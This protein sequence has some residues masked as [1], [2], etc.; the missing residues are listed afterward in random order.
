MSIWSEDEYA[1]ER[2]REE[3]YRIYDESVVRHRQ[4]LW[5]LQQAHEAKV[6][7][8]YGCNV[9]WTDEKIPEGRESRRGSLYIA[10]IEG[11]VHR[12]ARFQNAHY[13]QH[14]CEDGRCG[15]WV[16]GA[17]RETDGIVR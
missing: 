1:R 9:E 2:E 16:D 6:R 11:H 13:G 4:Y 14:H 15:A 8:L 7:Y 17:F 3:R 5:E 12:C 10:C